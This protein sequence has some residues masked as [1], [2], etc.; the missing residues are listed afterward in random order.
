MSEE[1]K[2]K[3][4][5]YSEGMKA[6]TMDVRM[7]FQGNVVDQAMRRW[8]QMKDP[9]RYWMA[10]RV[11][12][13]MDELEAKVLAEKEGVV[14]WKHAS[15]R[16]QVRALCYECALR[17]EELLRQFALPYD[18]QPAVRF[19]TPLNIPGLE[20]GTVTKVLLVGEMDLLTKKDPPLPDIVVDP[21]PIVLAYQTRHPELRVWDL[22]VTRSVDYWR[23]TVAQLV[24][25][26]IA[27]LCM[28]QIPTAEVGLL[29]P[30]VEGRP[31]LSFTP[32]EEDRTQMY[33]RIVTV[34]HGIMRGDYAPKASSAGCSYC[35][36]RGSCV[37]YQPRPGTRTIPLF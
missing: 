21:D 17:L 1:C 13:I 7:F 31:F 36:C 15:D 5:L 20:E 33:N 24:F 29:Q 32:S 35:E 22:K 10:Q 14:R 9:P 6:E 37:K 4:Y 23:K 27:C 11:D 28:F 26:D 12:E 2:Q 16:K 8:L 34:A 19:S 30:M 25:Y 18:Y 3:A